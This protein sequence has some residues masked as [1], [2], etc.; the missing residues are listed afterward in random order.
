MQKCSSSAQ[1]SALVEKYKKFIQTNSQTHSWPYPSIPAYSKYNA[2]YASLSQQQFNENCK[3]FVS[4]LSAAKTYSEY[5][6]LAN[7]YQVY[8]NHVTQ[9]HPNWQYMSI[10]AFMKKPSYK[11]PDDVTEAERKNLQFVNGGTNQATLENFKI[12]TAFWQNQITK[13]KTRALY[14]RAVN[15][16]TL[17]VKIYHSHDLDVQF[18]P[19]YAFQ[20]I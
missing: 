17:L 10:P 2:Q 15:L 20:S 11:I 13:C 6:K 9:Y 4:H 19:I 12:Q 3:L 14:D 1:Y 7:E 5:Q 16:L 8:I 18:P